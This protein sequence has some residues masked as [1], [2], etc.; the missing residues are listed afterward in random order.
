MAEPVTIGIGANKWIKDADTKMLTLVYPS[1]SSSQ[2]SLHNTETDTDYQVPSGKKF[3]ILKIQDT[4]GTSRNNANHD[5]YKNTVTNSVAGVNAI[6]R[7]TGSVPNYSSSISGTASVFY[8][9]D[10][11]IVIEAGKYIVSHCYGT[12]FNNASVTIIGIETNV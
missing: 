3:I 1:S 6:Y 8:P 9:K 7:A 11:Y 10:V 4:V 2:L 12:Q 5:L